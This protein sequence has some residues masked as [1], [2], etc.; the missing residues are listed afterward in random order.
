LVVVVD[1]VEVVV[2]EVVVDIEVVGVWDLLLPI[3]ELIKL[4][5][6][7]RILCAFFY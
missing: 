6:V 2:V 3:N 4:V 5:N 7:L 1:I